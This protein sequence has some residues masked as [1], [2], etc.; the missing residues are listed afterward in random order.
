MELIVNGGFDTD[1]AWTKGPGWSISGGKAVASS[2]ADL[3]AIS[4]IVTTVPGRK[5]RVSYSCSTKT[6]GLFSSRFGGSQYGSTAAAV[7]PYSEVFTASGAS[8]E[9]ALV[10][11]SAAAPDNVLTATFDD[12]SVTDVIQ[13]TA[14]ITENGDS[15]VAAGA[16]KVQASAAITEGDD[17][18]ASAGEVGPA[19]IVPAS[20]TVT[21]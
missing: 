12:V 10:Q 2:A 13:A 5:Y 7:G 18:L 1:T 16:V 19:A 15:L 21:I 17:V 11:R 6:F 8:T 9:I 14:A 20:R 3:A 4:Q